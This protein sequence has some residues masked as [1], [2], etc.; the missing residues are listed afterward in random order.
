MRAGNLFKVEWERSWGCL[1]WF[2]FVVEVC[3]GNVQGCARYHV[4]SDFGNGGGF[5]LLGG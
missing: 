5:I 2:S 3:W 1:F 4:G